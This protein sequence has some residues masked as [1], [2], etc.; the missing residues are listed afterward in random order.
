VN[1]Y[2]IRKKSHCAQNFVAA[3]KIFDKTPVLGQ[4]LQNLAVFTPRL[5][6]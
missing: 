3:R 1:H 6:C 2:T 5:G 4:D